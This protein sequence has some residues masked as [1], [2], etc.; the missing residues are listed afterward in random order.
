M[1]AGQDRDRMV[2]LRDGIAYRV[3]HSGVM[4]TITP[5]LDGST[6]VGVRIMDPKGR[7]LISHLGINSIADRVTYA[8]L[9]AR[10]DA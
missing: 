1:S 10:A 5:T 9:T 6:M 2:V 7:L 4:V 8:G 3:E